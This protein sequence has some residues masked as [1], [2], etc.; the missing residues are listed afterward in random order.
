MNYVC[1]S[2]IYSNDQG[3]AEIAKF[4]KERKIKEPK[5]KKVAR[6]WDK[7][8]KYILYRFGISSEN[9]PSNG[10]PKIPMKDVS[11]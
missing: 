7:M 8:L 5:G 6:N 11:F 2:F 10:V 3:A 9:M 1:N 4:I